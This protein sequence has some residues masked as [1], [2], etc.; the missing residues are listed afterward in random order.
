MYIAAATPN[1]FAY[2]VLFS[3]PLVAVILFRRLPL[4]AALIWTILL[5]YL[6]LPEKTGINLPMVPTFD[7]VLIPSLAAMVMVWASLRR[8]PQAEAGRAAQLNQAAGSGNRRPLGGR[9]RS[10]TVTNILLVIFVASPLLYYFDNSAPIWSGGRVLAGIQLYDVISLTITGLIMI[11]PFF[12]ARRHLATPETQRYL[13]VALVIA[14]LVYSV[15]M[16]VEIRLSPR[17]HSELYGFFPHS[18]AQHKRG[19]GYRPI[20]FLAH[21]LRVAIY[22]TMAMLAALALWRIRTGSR[23]VRWL[24][25]AAWIFVVLFMARNLGGFLL[26]FLLAPA[27][28]FLGARAQ[29]LLAAAIAGMALFYP[30]LRGA[31]LVPTEQIV[32]LAASI[33]EDRAESLAFRFENE[34]ALL[35]RANRKPFFGWGG[36]GRNMIFDER[37]GE[38]EAIP[39]GVWVIIMGQQGW[40]GYIAT[41]GLVCMPLI[42]IAW[43]RK[44]LQPDLVTSGLALVLA[45]NLIDMLPNSSLVPITWL[46]AGSLMGRYEMG[47]I[48]APAPQPD[49]PAAAQPRGPVYARHFPQRTP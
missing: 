46:I 7:K 40:V 16:L 24:W 1:L 42:L 6:F 43:R 2:L 45:V 12:L 22:M 49:A 27:V 25:A 8:Q 39:D 36:R 19:S 18:Y 9:Q 34:D 15:L 14:G 31:G 32:A 35:D 37:Y 41:F 44:L 3:F 47:R 4:H 48:R 21:G 10:T 17:L 13:L 29:I 28:L 33:D 5:G 30:M 20:V 23:P 26:A 38:S 11:M